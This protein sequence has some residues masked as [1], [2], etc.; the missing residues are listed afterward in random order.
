MSVR[1]D[2]IICADAFRHAA[3]EGAAP[4][5]AAACPAGPESLA[6]WLIKNDFL[7]LREALLP[8]TFEFMDGVKVPLRRSR[9]AMASYRLEVLKKNPR[10]QKAAARWTSS[11]PAA[12]A[13]SS[14]S[15]VEADE[16][17]VLTFCYRCSLERPRT[18]DRVRDVLA[19]F[20]RHYASGSC[21]R[22]NNQCKYCH[23]TGGTACTAGG[24]GSDA[25]RAP[26]RSSRQ[27]HPRAGVKNRKKQQ[28]TVRQH[29]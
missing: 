27:G 7:D 29:D 18:T 25:R 14:A 10:K 20:C 19:S 12:P 5:E 11:T 3:N 24:A 8:G 9:S 28:Q 23:C 6:P 21:N 4:V 17:E 26:K 22:N 15:P 16:G 13:T 1:T 2:S